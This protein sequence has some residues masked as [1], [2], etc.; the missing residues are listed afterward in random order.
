VINNQYHVDLTKINKSEEIEDKKAII[1]EDI[2]NF[3]MDERIEEE[4][5]ASNFKDLF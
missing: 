5:D 2:E 4:V 3:S 1:K